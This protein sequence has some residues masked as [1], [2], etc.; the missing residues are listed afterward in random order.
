MEE[1]A[2]VRGAA[3]EA[4]RDVVPDDLRGEMVSLLESGSTVPGSLTLVVADLFGDVDPSGID[5]LTERAVGVQLIYV[6][7]RLTRRLANEDPWSGADGAADVPADMEILAAN[8]LVSRGFY[9]LARTEAAAAAVGVVRSFGRDQTERREREDP[10][11]DR[12]LERDVV[13]LAV[14]AG[15]TA[16][17]ADAPETG[18]FAADLVGDRAGFPPAAELLTDDVVDRLTELGGNEVG[19]T[20]PRSG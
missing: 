20:A 2:A 6:G 5:G 14:L 8:V 3:E 10:T 17:G 11:L 19:G 13:E 9:L 12:E 15:A 1:A 4:V 18:A 7:L 16:V